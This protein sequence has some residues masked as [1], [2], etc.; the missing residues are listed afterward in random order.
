MRRGAF[1]NPEAG[2]VRDGRA[3]QGADLRDVPSQARHAAGRGD[4]VL[5]VV[6]SGVVRARTNV[7][8]ERLG[9]L[10]LE[11]SFSQPS[12]LRLES[13]QRSFDRCVRQFDDRAVLVLGRLQRHARLRRILV[14]A[15]VLTVLTLAAVRSLIRR[16]AVAILL[17]AD[18]IHHQPL[19]RFYPLVIV[20]S[21]LP[22]FLLPVIFPRRRSVFS[23]SSQLVTFQPASNVV[24]QLCVP[25]NRLQDKVVGASQGGVRMVRAMPV[26]MGESHLA[27]R[28]RA[29]KW[30]LA[31]VK[32]LVRLQ[33]ARLCERL[34]AAWIVARIRTLAYNKNKK[35]MYFYTFDYHRR[36]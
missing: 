27:A 11:A 20:R 6:A 13:V 9:E 34:C 21:A 26:S 1:V 23:L 17:L 35:A 22:R 29:Q 16:L 15:V 2:A 18:R 14:L 24:R 30:L 7:P 3:V 5:L 10:L 36:V 31:S 28:L 33:L 4:A 19:S 8:S 25:R 12:F 32:S